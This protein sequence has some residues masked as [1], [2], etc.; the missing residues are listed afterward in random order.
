M[1]LPSEDDVDKSLN[2]LATT[3]EAYAKSTARVKALEYEVKTVKALAFLDAQGTV[4][5]R[6]AI[7]E[8]SSAFRAW[9]QGYENA[10]ADMK[11]METKRKRAELNI[12]VW[13]SLNASRRQG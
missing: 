4:G 10:F 1:S 3:D 2:Y 7:S 9:V 12:D 5:E 8:A 13:R 11:I 6:T